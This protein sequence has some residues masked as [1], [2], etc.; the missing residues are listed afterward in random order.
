MS[1][2]LYIDNAA[3]SFPKPP[4]VT[5]AMVR[6][7]TDLG[8]S[9]G[10]GGYAE[11]RATGDLIANC[12]RV[13]CELFNGQNVNHFVFTLNCSDA[14]NL[15]IKGLID[16]AAKAHVICTATDHNSILRPINAMVE[17]GWITSTVVP[18]DPQTGLV[19]PADVRKAIRPDTKFI[20]ITHASNVTGAVQP[21]RA[22]GK[23]AREM[24]VPLIVD[25][26]QSAGHVPIDVQ[27]DCIDLLAVP[28]HKALMGPLGTGFL[29]LRPGMEKIVRP[30][31]E[32]GTG[33]VSEHPVQPQFMPDKYEPGS[34][35][36]IGLAGLAAGAAW[37]M[38]Q[39][40]E[41]L[42]AQ[43][44]DQIRAFLDGIGGIEG[45]TYYGPRG[46]ANRIGVFSVRV[47]GYSP[48][49]LADA[50]EKDFGVLTR[51]GLHCAPHIHE[52]IGTASAGGTTRLSFGPFISTQDIRYATDALAQV[53]GAV[54]K[55]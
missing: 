14:L 26:A 24:A 10:R 19:D 21:V 23:L 12:R 41:K 15:A 7:A 1:R 32:G 18:V 44:Q 11:A 48:T 28:G 22:I 2:R 27:A 16:P 4:A 20:A 47:D 25:A 3:T 43:E 39:G 38:E 46:V 33:S 55:R 8:A 13:L 45:L 49:E 31:R 37:V 6:Y 40:L 34:H 29:Y 9:A 17:R 42:H 51:P 35:N 30:L 50:L 5:E 36:A 52:A 53:A 54:L